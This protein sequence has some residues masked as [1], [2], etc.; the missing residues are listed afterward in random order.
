LE[1]RLGPDDVQEQQQLAG[2]SWPAI[3][4]ETIQGAINT[5]LISATDQIVSIYHR[6]RLVLQELTTALISCGTLLHLDQSL[7]LVTAHVLGMI[8]EV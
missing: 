6:C 2:G 4:R 8:V 3:V 7:C 1:L 5:S